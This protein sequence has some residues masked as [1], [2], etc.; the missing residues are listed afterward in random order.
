MINSAIRALALTARILEYPDVGDFEG[1]PGQ[2][3]REIL[4]DIRN[5]PKLTVREALYR[6]AIEKFIEVHCQS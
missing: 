2:T 6:V 4:D 5:L 3:W 1:A